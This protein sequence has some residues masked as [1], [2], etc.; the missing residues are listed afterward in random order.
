VGLEV[1]VDTQ[2]DR[3]EYAREVSQKQIR[4]L[5]LFDS[6]P[7]ST[8]RV[9]TEKVSSDEGGLWW[10]GVHDRQV[11]ALIGLAHRLVEPEPRLKA[12]Q[13]CLTWLR[14]NPHWL[15]LYHPVRLFGCHPEVPRS[16]V[17]SVTANS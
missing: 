6:S 14:H 12:Y 9:L 2:P 11:D 1:H 15:Y 10:Q 3:P 16:I 5:S 7:W 8:F 13:Q 4:D 17:A